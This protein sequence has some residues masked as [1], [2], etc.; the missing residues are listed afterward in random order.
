MNSRAILPLAL[1]APIY[2][3]SGSGEKPSFR[4]TPGTSQT[5]SIEIENEVELEDMSMELNGVD[6]SEM[7]GQVE[8][9][10]KVSMKL[11]V[12]DH[13]LTVD[14]G[15]PT[16]L[17]RSYDE[18][19]SLT[20]V[21]G[22]NPAT[23]AE[24]K[25]IPL[26][27]EL[28]GSTVVFSWNADDEEYRA[29]FDGD[30]QG[31]DDLLAALREDL[32]LRGFLPTGEVS[33]GDTW[34]VPADAVKAVLAPGGDMKL[35]PDGA[36]DSMGGMEQ[37]SQNDMI[38]ELDGKFDAVYAGTRDEDGTKVAVIKLTLDANSAQDMS[39]RLDQMKEQMKGNLPDEVEVDL[40]AMDSEFDYEAEGELLWNLE[41]GLPFGL[42]LSGEVRMIIDMAMTMKMGEQEQAMDISQTF[43]GTQTIT[44]TTGG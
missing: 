18:I 28:E 39:S 15:R 21:S 8:L 17:R 41:S 26:A 24:E 13:Y 14:G 25:D 27:S 31:D 22:S 35:R 1:L 34:K 6:M 36:V 43:S 32:D 16:R 33:E 4:P 29:E 10:M 38:G 9:A 3:G 11:A 44:M 19:S 2:L 7:A 30:S 42:H 23:G 20:H 5:K 12:T 37:F 40:S